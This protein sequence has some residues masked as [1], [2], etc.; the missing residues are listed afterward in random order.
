MSNDKYHVDYERWIRKD[1]GS[2]AYHL[3]KVYI[4]AISEILWWVKGKQLEYS[5]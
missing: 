2:N 3:C 5:L 1:L 4:D